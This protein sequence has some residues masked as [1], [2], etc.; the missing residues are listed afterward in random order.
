MA[1]LVLV[2]DPS[3]KVYGG[4]S[5]IG[6]KSHDD[7]VDHRRSSNNRSV[8]E[9]PVNEWHQ[10]TDSFVFSFENGSDIRN[11]KV[12]RP[13]R[14]QYAI[15]V[16][17]RSGSNEF[18]F[19]FGNCFYMSGQTVYLNYP[20]H[21]KDYVINRNMSSIDFIPEEIEFFDVVSS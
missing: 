14:S 13:K 2:R 17:R 12:S 9:I 16:N 7:P 6:F 4:Y 10:T 5:P 19:N 1:I 8:W 3:S 18:N 21:Y 11:V 20:S 15:G